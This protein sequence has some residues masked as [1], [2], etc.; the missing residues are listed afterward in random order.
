[1]RIAEIAVYAKTL[2]LTEPYRM[3]STCLDAVETT[4]VEV[5]SDSGVSGWGE[6][7]PVGPS[8]APAHALGARAALAELAPALIGG[9]ALA[10]E[11]A[12]TRMNAALNGHPYAKAAIDIAL[13]DLAGKHYGASVAALLGGAMA[14]TVPAYYAVGVASPEETAEIARDRRDQGV[15]AHPDQSWR[16]VGGGGR[17]G[18][19]PDR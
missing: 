6:T 4:L 5:V 15:S 8:Y 11:A 9:D 12:W 7:C 14:E 13:W 3:A 16:S 19:A 18:G 2:P 1:M 17:R 10:I